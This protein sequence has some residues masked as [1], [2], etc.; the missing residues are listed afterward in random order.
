MIPQEMDYMIL[1]NDRVHLKMVQ[2]T[3]GLDLFLY[4]FL[5]DLNQRES[6]RIDVRL[7][8]TPRFGKQRI[9]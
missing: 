2:P 4:S 1:T 3:C 6:L 7:I 5:L 8:R 9:Q